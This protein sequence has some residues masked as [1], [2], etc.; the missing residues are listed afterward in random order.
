[1]DKRGG[2]LGYRKKGGNEIIVSKAAGCRKR[3]EM[4][5]KIDT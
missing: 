1:M 3:G 2:D 4:L 5:R